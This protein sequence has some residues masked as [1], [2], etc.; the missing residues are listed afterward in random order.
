MPSAIDIQGANGFGAG[1]KREQA[2][3]IYAIGDIHGQ[4]GML[5]AAHERIAADRAHT[6]DMDAPVVHLGDLT[7]RGPDSNGV[8]QYLIDGIAR[9][10]P[11]LMVKGNHDRMFAGFL[12][13]PEYH[14]PGL[15]TGLT[16]LHPRLGG[17]ET[18]VSYGVAAD[19]PHSEIQ[20]AVPDSHKQFLGKRPSPTSLDYNSTASTRLAC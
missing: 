3:R 9:G 10:E 11:W 17:V 2:M 15:T 16:W 12:E 19:T 13:D 14:D 18:L 7:D 8:I 5:H 4:I 1:I 20:R 6:G